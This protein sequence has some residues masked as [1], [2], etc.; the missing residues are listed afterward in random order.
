MI[1]SNN[2]DKY[3]SN[4]EQH[5]EAYVNQYVVSSAS[6]SVS[7]DAINHIKSAMLY[8]LNAGGKRIRPTLLLE[9]TCAYG[10]QV[11]KALEYALAIEMIHTY[12]LIHDD[13]PCMDDDDLRRGK[14]TNHVVYGEDIATLAGDALLNLASE[15]MISACTEHYGNV[16]YLHAMREILKASGASGMILGQ[17]ADIK[18]HEKTV[19][20]HTDEALKMLD[21]IN[22]N[23]TGQLLT[24]AI[25]SGAYLGG[26]PEHEIIKLREIGRQVG[27]LFQIVDDVLDVIGDVEKLG[28]RTQI[29]AKNNKLTYPGIL[30]IE[31]T[32]NVIHTLKV[33]LLKQI[34]ALEI[35]KQFLSNLIVF[36]AEREF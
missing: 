1:R 3:I 23:K 22:E 29:D 32:K 26:A 11:E 33:S 10:G 12:S 16:N 20:D 21:F 30:G 31:E 25:V 5:F 35:D 14:P 18:H 34:E 19:L 8:S 28:K 36:L 17:V 9:M 24:A 27:L 4:I 7:E 6:N 15:L 2:V 13:L